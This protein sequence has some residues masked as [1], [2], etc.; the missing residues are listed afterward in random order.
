MQRRQK[1]V[2]EFQDVAQGR[3]IRLSRPAASTGRSRASTT[4]PCRCRSPTRSASRS[5][6]PPSA[7][8]RAR[9][10]SSRNRATLNHEQESSLETPH[11]PR[12]L[13]H[14]LRASASTRSWRSGIRPAAARLADGASSCKLGL[15]L[16]GGVHLVL[17]VQTDDALQDSDDDDER[18]AARGAADRGRH[19]SSS[20][21]RHRADDVP[22]RRRAGRTATRDFRAHRRRPGGARTTTATPAPAA[23]TTSR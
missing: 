18:A 11:Q 3:G 17:R 7:A 20:I 2:Q 16:K 10:R 8:T 22:G 21:T 6:G 4:N 23:P 1:K 14:L 12:R 19:A 15:D 5:P 9:S 13:R